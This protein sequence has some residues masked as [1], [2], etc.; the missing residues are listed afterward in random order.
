MA[1][2]ALLACEPLS[3]V[4]R[5]ANAHHLPE[6][7]LDWADARGLDHVQVE[8]ELLDTGGALGRLE[9]RGELVSENV[10]VH[11]GDLV[12]GIDLAAAWK[13]HLDSGAEATLLV[14]DRPRVNTVAVRDGRF[15]GVVGH[16]RGP[17]EIPAGCRARTFTG[18]AFYRRR[19]LSGCPD[20][21][22]SVKELWHDLLEAGRPIRVLELPDP[23]RWSDLGTGA[24]FRAEVRAELSRRGI[25]LWRDPSSLV[26]DTARILPGSVV[27]MGAEVGAGACVDGAILLPGARVLPGERVAGILRNGSGDLEVEP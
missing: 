27:E 6:Q 14:V 7:I 12:H 20:R 25:A 2:R 17:R 15:A 19:I 18:I 13:A 4:R 11:N 22:W 9:S 16:P 26:A 21:P 8:P 23:V 10:L 1:D 5:V 24:D 3:P